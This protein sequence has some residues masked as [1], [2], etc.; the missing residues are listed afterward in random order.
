MYPFSCFWKT[1]FLYFLTFEKGPP[2][3]FENQNFKSVGG[4]LQRKF[5]SKG[6]PF[7]KVKKCKNI[8][9]QKHENGYI[10]R[11]YFR[12]FYLYG[13]IRWV[14]GFEKFRTI[15]FST[16]GSVFL[17]AVVAGSSR[18][19]NQDGGRKKYTSKS[20]EKNGTE[21]FEP[22]WKKFFE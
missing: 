7:S 4:T 16:F 22:Q 3:A 11:I 10:L 6:G 18:R 21:L 8:V 5:F 1:M 2:Y 12:F 15:F 20:G 14:C 9:F 19:V 13:G 17:Q